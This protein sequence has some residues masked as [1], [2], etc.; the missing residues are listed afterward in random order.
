MVKVIQCLQLYVIVYIP[1][2]LLRELHFSWGRHGRGGG[3]DGDDDI[4]E[5]LERLNVSL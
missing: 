4:V 5:Y 3:V 1:I 2:L